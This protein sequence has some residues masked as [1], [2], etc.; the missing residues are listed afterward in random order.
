V[1]TVLITGGASLIGEGIAQCLAEAGWHVVVSD[2]ALATAEQ[3][4]KPLGSRA[5]ALALD[6]TNRGDIVAAI[7]ALEQRFGT[8][9][10]LVNCA[11]GFRGLGLKRKPFSQTT[12]DEWDRILDANLKGVLNCCHAVLPG[13][14]RAGSGNIVSISA[15]R[16]L[17]GG[18]M[19]AL[20]SAAKA[21]IIVFSQSLA[22]EVGEHGIRV[23][24][25]APGNADAR[26]KTD[27]MSNTRAPLGRATNGRDIGNAVTFLLSAQASHITGS[28]IDVSGGTALH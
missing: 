16:G 8:I 13:M 12:P 9:D 11:G 7:L 1:S 6:V 20:Y 3:V 23:N 19:A 24:T 26:W 18:P 10:A 5:E 14:I 15:S 28:C 2:I 21:A 25:I 27:D 4:A 22:Q 17:R